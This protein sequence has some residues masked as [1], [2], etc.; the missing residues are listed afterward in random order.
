[1]HPVMLGFLE[2]RIQPS[3]SLIRQS[4]LKWVNIDP[5]MP[6]TAATVASTI[7]RWPSR[8]AKNVSAQKRSNLASCF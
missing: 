6:G 7:A 8:L 1:M 3:S 2:Q 5:T 4:E